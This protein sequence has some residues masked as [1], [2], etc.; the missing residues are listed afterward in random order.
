L[1]KKK[2]VAMWERIARERERE[3]MR[4]KGVYVGEGGGGL[5]T[6]K[7]QAVWNLAA[8]T[9]PIASIGVAP[10]SAYTCGTAVGG[11]SMVVA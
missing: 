8:D 5:A 1:K 10:A 7:E 9:S 3:R 11:V 4:E 2:A 6:M